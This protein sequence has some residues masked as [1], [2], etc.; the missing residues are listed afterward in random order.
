MTIDGFRQGRDENGWRMAEALWKEERKE[1]K[2]WDRSK[3]ESEAIL[4]LVSALPR[5]QE[6]VRVLRGLMKADK[7]PLQG[8]RGTARAYYGFG[9][10]SGSGFGATI[11]INGQIHYEYGQ[12]CAEST[13]KKSSNWRE[14]NNLVE[15]IVCMVIE[16]DLR[17]SEIFIFTD[18]STAEA[19]F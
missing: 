17:G 18:N 16:H 1:D 12:W 13:E 4:E 10:A 6:D 3:V 2:D 9:N 14:V 15:A 19:A 11:Q 8:A 7:P 5:F